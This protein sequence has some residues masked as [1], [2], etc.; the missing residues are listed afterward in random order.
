M[1]FRGPTTAQK[2]CCTMPGF[3]ASLTS[4][5]GPVFHLTD[6]QGGDIKQ[7]QEML[8]TN[9][10]QRAWSTPQVVDLDDRGRSREAL[11]VALRL[12]LPDYIPSPENA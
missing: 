1:A 5:A 8:H 3:P 4:F 11:R 6:S 7:P 9:A 2:P 12:C 10:G